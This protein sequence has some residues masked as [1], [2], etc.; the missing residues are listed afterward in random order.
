MNN[1]QIQKNKN[2]LSQTINQDKK[3]LDFGLYWENSF[4]I[5]EHIRYR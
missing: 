1:P 4:Q 5:L 3:A 2:I